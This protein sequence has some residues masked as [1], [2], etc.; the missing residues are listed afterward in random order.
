MKRA[1]SESKM[2]ENKVTQIGIDEA[3]R[4]VEWFDRI[5]G[6]S[7]SAQWQVLGLPF[8]FA[9][10]RGELSA[11]KADEGQ[12]WGRATE[13]ISVTSSSLTNA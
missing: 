13:Q 6:V 3:R 12:R 10:M 1:N 11:S 5:T 2:I 8:L 4:H 7:R 9:S